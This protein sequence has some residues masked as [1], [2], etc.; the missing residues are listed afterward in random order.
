MKNLVR[1]MNQIIGKI[2][3]MKEAKQ[4]KGLETVERATVEVK[5]ENTKM[6]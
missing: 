2:D 1:E 6:E 4:I 5:E 3:A